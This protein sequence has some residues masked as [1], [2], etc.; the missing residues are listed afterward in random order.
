M[1]WGPGALR[2]LDRYRLGPVSWVS[3]VFVGGVA[4]R[5]VPCLKTMSAVV[6]GEHEE[7]AGTARQPVLLS[8]DL[9]LVGTS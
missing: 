1:T 3:A 8:R 9:I 2:H 5:G 6:A 7:A 4:W